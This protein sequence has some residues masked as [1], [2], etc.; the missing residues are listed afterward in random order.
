MQRNVNVRPLRRGPSPVELRLA[1][2]ERH[3]FW[4][5]VWVGMALTV[6]AS[7]AAILFVLKMGAI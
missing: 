4:L 3:V 6:L 7:L 2:V 1:A 5:R